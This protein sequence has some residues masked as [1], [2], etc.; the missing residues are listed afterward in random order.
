MA[1]TT[2]IRRL[3]I[4]MRMWFR[5][6]FF[7]T[8]CML[9][10]I[11]NAVYAPSDQSLSLDTTNR[12]LEGDECPLPADPKWTIALYILGVCYMFIGL[13]IIADDFFVP[14]LDL[15]SEVWELP[16]D[17]AGATLMAAGGSS[18]E[19][20]TSAMGTFLRSSVGFGA[21]VG[22][23]VFNLLFVIGICSC[24]TDKPMKLTWYPIT[25]DSIYYAIVLVVLA[26]FF[27]VNTPQVIDWYEALILHLMYWGYVYLMSRNQ[28]VYRWAHKLIIPKDSL[29]KDA[30]T[31]T[32]DAPAEYFATSNT[33]REG[34]LKLLTKKKSILETVGSHV[35]TKT[36]MSVEEIFDKYDSNHDHK[37]SR[38]EIKSFFGDL[39]VPTND[40]ELDAIIKCID[41]NNDGMID[42][43]ELSRWYLSSDKRVKHDIAELFGSFDKDKSGTIDRHEMLDLISSL[44]LTKRIIGPD[45]LD[46]I[47]RDVH[48]EASTNGITLEQFTNWYVHSIHMA[49]KLKEGE[50]LEEAA[51]G[52]N[53][54]PPSG[55]DRT[56]STMFWYVAT[57][58]LVLCFYVTVF[59]V[60]KPSNSKYVWLSFFTCL[61]WFGIFSYFMVNWIETIGAT[62]GIP[63]VIM[64]LTFLA[65]GTSVPDMLSAVIVARKGEAD[66]AVSSSIGSNVFDVC[67]GLAFPW[68]LFIAVYQESVYVDAGQLFISITVLILCIVAL[69]GTIKYLNWSLNKNAG[70]WLI[71]LYF[72]YVAQQLAIA[73]WG[74]C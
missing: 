31:E 37:L 68:L 61:G 73:K 13:A 44:A 47:M 33:I 28:D 21:I 36:L 58:P 40:A 46:E 7:P 41:T 30:N 24:I 64:G 10:V 25:R 12:R 70:Y 27:G 17:V 66:K 50:M 55:D 19:L 72:C 14:T 1:V 62:I 22:S 67:I 35:V 5:L 4:R 8:M 9:Y 56:C 18:P 38:E 45:E 49:D 2:D 34:V 43:D 29:L 53:I 52:I 20:F 48:V 15:I 3:K 74:S 11:Y 59:D 57:L 42:F 39:L 65:A 60:R 63:S 71:F 32:D 23:A 69:V 26:I 51:E 54:Y 16:A 6:A